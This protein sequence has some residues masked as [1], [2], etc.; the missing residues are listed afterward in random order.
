MAVFI[1]ALGPFSLAIVNYGVTSMFAVITLHQ[2][3][4]KEDI[5]ED[6]PGQPLK[7]VNENDTNIQENKETKETTSDNNQPKS[8]INDETENSNEKVNNDSAEEPSEC[9]VCNESRIYNM[10][11]NLRDKFSFS[12]NE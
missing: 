12:E 3:Y 9:D 10:F 6:T 2:L 5:K 1:L 7:S 11:K 4:D 8:T